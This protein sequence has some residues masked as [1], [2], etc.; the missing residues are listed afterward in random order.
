MVMLKPRLTIQVNLTENEL[1]E[2]SSLL[3]VTTHQHNNHYLLSNT[4]KCIRE[5]SQFRKDGTDHLTSFSG[6]TEKYL[7]KH[8]NE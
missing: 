8:I 1:E 2:C 3:A 7:M 5:N 4:R 6:S